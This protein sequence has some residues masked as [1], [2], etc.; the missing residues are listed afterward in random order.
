MRVDTTVRKLARERVARPNGDDLGDFDVL[1]ADERTSTIYAIECKDLE[2]ART[3]AE[4]DN[5]LTNTFRAGGGRRSAAEKHVERIAWLR[6]RTNKALA[7]LG[8]KEPSGSWVIRGA[9]VT[10]VNVMSPHVDSCPLP[11]YALHEL[12][13]TLEP[14]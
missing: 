9:I 4:L 2:V 3:P 13:A 7:H 1:A 10:D 11:V 6:T 8:V 5:E 12:R 14:V